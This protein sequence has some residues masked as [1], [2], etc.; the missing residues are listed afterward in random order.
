MKKFLILIL[1]PIMIGCDSEPSVTER[2]K[3]VETNELIL[4]NQNGKSYQL[5]VDDSG[6]V[7]AIEIPKEE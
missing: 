7:K 2:F 5:Q 3:R 4:I 1:L 6:N